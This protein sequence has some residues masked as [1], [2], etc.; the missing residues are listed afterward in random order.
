[1]KMMLNILPEH[2]L[3]GSNMVVVAGVVCGLKVH[4]V[5][6]AKNIKVLFSHV[7]INKMIIYSNGNVNH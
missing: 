6:K 5:N 4:I 2:Q 1:M 3:V 7:T